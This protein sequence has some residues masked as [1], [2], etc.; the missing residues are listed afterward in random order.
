[1]VK[2]SEDIESGWFINNGVGDKHL[3]LDSFAWHWHNSS[4][5]HL[6]I[7]E[8]SKFYALQKLTNKR[9]KEKGIL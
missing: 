4:K 8:G 6:P 5:K 3:F 7:Q 9:L 2:L 1:M